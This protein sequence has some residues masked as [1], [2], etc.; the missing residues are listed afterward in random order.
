M[1]NK[2]SQ[3][4]LPTAAN[5]LGFCLIVITSLHLS[6]ATSNSIIDEVASIV[7]VLLCISVILSFASIKSRSLIWTQRWE[8]LAEILFGASIIGIALIVLVL[9]KKF[10]LR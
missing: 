2:T 7:S 8:N 5:L 6:S 1:S 4:I 10:S 9:L 3:H